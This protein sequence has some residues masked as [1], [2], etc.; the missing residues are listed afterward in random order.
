MRISFRSAAL[1]STLATST[2]LSLAA[3]IPAASA[4]VPGSTV[5]TAASLAAHPALK[6]PRISGTA[7][8]SQDGVTVVVDFRNLANAAGKKMNLIRI[9]CAEGAQQSGFT[10]LLGAGF[11]V[12]PNRPFVCTIDDRPI[13]LPGCPP[14]DGYWSYSHGLRGHHWKSSSVGAGDW[15][16]PAGSLEGWSWSPYAKTSPWNFPRVSPKKL[17]PPNA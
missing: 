1:V 16:P 5:S 10:A 17:F 7:C 12:D 11:D 13:D 14:P 3:V 8:T 6:P 2:I 15:T 4:A 9:G